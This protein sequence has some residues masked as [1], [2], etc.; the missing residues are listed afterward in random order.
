MNSPSPAD[1]STHMP[2]QGS[3]LPALLVC[4]VALFLFLPTV[5]HELVYDDWFLIDP[6]QNASMQGI[7]DD[8]GVALRLFGEEYW[9]GVNPSGVEELKNRGQAL[10]RPLTTFTWAAL[11]YVTKYKGATEA[12]AYHLTN[13]LL[14]VLAVFLLFRLIIRLFGSVRLAV[15][16]SLLFAV[17]PL[18][19]EVVAYVA[20]LSDLL[21]TL[22]VLGGLLFWLR[23]IEDPVKLR[24]GAYIGLLLTLFLGLLAKEAAVLLLAVVALTDLMLTLRGRVISM[25][26]RIATY[27]GMI[28]VIC[29][30]IG[31]RYSVLGYLKPSSSAISTLDNV[32]INTETSLRMANAF[33][34]IAK[35]LWL[36]LWPKN[37]SVDYSKSAIDVSQHWTDP[38]PLTGLILVSVLVIVG[39]AKLRTSP[40]FAWGILLFVGCATFVS[41]MFV[42]IG[43]IMGERLMYLPSAGL[44]L[45]VAVILDYMLKPGG[46]RG[47][48]LNPLG[49]LLAVVVIGATALR[50]IE[51]NAEFENPRVLFEAAEKV[52]PTS[53]RV[54]FQLGTLYFNQGLYDTATQHLETSLTHDPNFIR[55]AIQMGDVHYANLN[56]E[57]AISVF[58]Q[59]LGSV[60]GDGADPGDLAAL[61]DMVLKKRA[62]SYRQNGDLELAVAD[63]QAAASLGIPSSGAQSQLVS[64]LQGQQRWEES[65]PVIRNA[66]V[67]DPGNVNLLFALCRAAAR[68]GD[69]A[70]YKESLAQL[71]ETEGGRAL[72]LSME[73][74]TLY[75]QA[76]AAEDEALRSQ[77]MDKFE[78]AIELDDTLATPYAFRGRYMAERSRYL[79]DAI[80]EYDRAL[81][82]D[83]LHSMALS[84]KATALLQLFDFEA[85]LATLAILETVNPNPELL[86]LKAEAYFGLGQLE[87]LETT[88]E[89]LRELGIDPIEIILNTA[90]TYDDQGDTERALNLLSQAFSDPEAALNPRLWRLLGIINLSAGHYE[91]ALVAFTE[92]L[93]AT[94]SNPEQEGPFPYIPLNKARSLIGL[95][96][97][98]EAAA[99]LE[100]ADAILMGL[101]EQHP[102][103]RTLRADVLLTRADLFL[104]KSS[105]LFNPA[106]AEEL[107][108]EGMAHTGNQYPPFYDRS[109][110]A[111]VD[112][113]DLTSALERAE[114]AAERFHKLKRYSVIVQ[115]LQLAQNGDQAG[116]IARLK[117]AEESDENDRDN[118]LSR[119]AATLA[120]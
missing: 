34:I 10:Y 3:A 40:A 102:L 106:R 73:A 26:H 1:G 115:A 114:F 97:D 78:Q 109:I 16:A 95:Q 56:W 69:K 77:A 21:S 5:G 74:S 75:V 118:T 54:H 8:F 111:L 80:I 41:N 39:L 100:E 103:W 36:V 63:L 33:K 65:V 96:Q 84:L 62:E 32:L 13:V 59:I 49:V 18:H 66:L 68:M 29:M 87:E 60:K 31:L 47:G 117:S 20:G 28:V 112:A 11:S 17:H 90:I 79:H 81:E 91:E 82:R 4:L 61:Q 76:L 37:L 57:K 64:M 9:E 99:Q 105:S 2:P 27:L 42:P 110:E 89:Q 83:P 19:S 67:L 113:N 43:T 30:N 46:G 52:V 107:C 120:G 94:L 45:A 104:M 35:Y 50:T 55:A 15:L 101:E 98:M 72:A 58:T 92:Q 38:G 6:G 51:R 88:R 71:K 93:S 7:N 119:L 85:A 48:K 24:M 116:A 25:S 53:A 23:T 22:A 14:N 70:I 86:R 108:L 12:V 44:C